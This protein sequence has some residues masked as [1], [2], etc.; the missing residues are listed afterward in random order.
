MELNNLL[1]SKGISPEK[2]MA[3]RHRPAEP[4]LR[5]VLPWLA[6]ERQEIFNAYQKSHDEKVEKALQ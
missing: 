5:K 4:M 1:L 6:L 3:F 2:V